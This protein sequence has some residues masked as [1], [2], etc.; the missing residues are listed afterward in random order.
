[1]MFFNHG[2]QHSILFV[3]EK[4]RILFLVPAGFIVLMRANPL[5]QG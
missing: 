5:P 3:W 1:M 4:I 2:D